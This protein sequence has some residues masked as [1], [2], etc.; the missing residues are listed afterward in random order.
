MR[1]L[2]L[3]FYNIK[4]QRRDEEASYINV[5]NKIKKNSKQCLFAKESFFFCCTKD[6]FLDLHFVVLLNYYRA[7]HESVLK[8]I[9]K[10]IYM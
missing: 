8:F 3:I 7:R 4:I 10:N 5:E 2:Y 1:K 6:Q 9:H